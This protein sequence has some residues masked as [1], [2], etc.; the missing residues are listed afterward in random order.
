MHNRSFKIFTRQAVLFWGILLIALGIRTGCVILLGPY[1]DSGQTMSLDASSYHQIAQ[2]LVERHIFTSAVD[3]PYNPQQPGTFRPPLTPFFLATIYTVFRVDLFWGRLGLAVLSAISCG[4]TYWLGAKLFGQT[5]GLVAGSISCV[6]PFF[7]LLVL[8]PLTEGISIFLTLALIM[9]LYLSDPQENNTEE[10][11]R[12]LFYFFQAICVGLTFG[13]V[14][15]N[16]AS[17]IVLLPCILFWGLFR[18]SGTRTIRLVRVFIVLIVTTVTILPWSLRNH[19]ITGAFIPINS[20][21][22]WTFYLGNNEHT[23]KNLR[24]LEEGRTNGWVPPKE[25]F[26]PFA[27]L[28]FNDTQNYEKRAIRLGLRF[29]W[30]NPG[31][32]INYALRKLKIFWSAYPHIFDKLSWYPLAVCCIF[33]FWHSLKSWKKHLV[34]YLL[35][36]S[37]MSIPLVFTSMPRF[38]APIMPFLIIY[39][40]VGLD[41]I[42]QAIKQMRRKIRNPKQLQ[43][44]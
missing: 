20:N 1:L 44:T 2:N 18:L 14:L 19:A 39:G 22:G 24:A 3:P 31:T 23:E 16:K 40:V 37:S 36:I 26:A 29:I 11:T 35:I 12:S 38:R 34:I 17:N 32:V 43:I 21:G 13:F 9:L 33:G 8:L 6:Y 27:D 30:Q 7:L 25:V 42:G 28:Q 4:L 41:R 5:I 15:L 10:Q